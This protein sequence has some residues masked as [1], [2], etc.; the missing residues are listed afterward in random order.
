MSEFSTEEARPADPVGRV[1]FRAARWLAVF[2][3]LVLCIMALMTTISVTGR[4][5]FDLPVPGDFELVAIGTSTAVFAFL[6]Y[7]QISRGNVIVDFFMVGAPTRAKTVCDTV[8]GLFY[9]AVGVLLTWRMYFGAV[10]MYSYGEKTMTINFP[11]WVTFPYALACMAF[12]IV[13]IAY[14]VGRS[15]AETRANRLFD[16]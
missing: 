3:G 15:V 4:A 5:A 10:D 1:L 9:L 16:E 14:T 8:G 2:G 11:R 6:P 7:C 12:L 13:V